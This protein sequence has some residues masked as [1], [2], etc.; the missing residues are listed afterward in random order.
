MK[1]THSI[2]SIAASL[3]LILS[4]NLDAMD[5]MMLPLQESTSSEIIPLLQRGRTR[6]RPVPPTKKRK[7]KK[8]P[9]TVLSD[10]PTATSGL[11]QTFSAVAASCCSNSQSSKE[12]QHPPELSLVQITNPQPLTASENDATTFRPPPPREKHP[13][14]RKE[15]PSFHPDAV[16]TNEYGGDELEWDDDTSSVT[17]LHSSDSDHGDTDDETSEGEGGDTATASNAIVTSATDEDNLASVGEDEVADGSDSDSDIDEETEVAVKYYL[18]AWT[19]VDTSGQ[20]ALNLAKKMS[21][22]SEYTNRLKKNFKDQSTAR[23]VM[24][25]GIHLYLTNNET[26]LATYK[27]TKKT[28]LQSLEKTEAQNKEPELLTSFLKLLTRRQRRLEAS[29]LIVKSEVIQPDAEILLNYYNACDTQQ[30]EIKNFVQSA[31]DLGLHHLKRLESM[32]NRTYKIISRPAARIVHSSQKMDSV[33]F[34]AQL[35]DKNKSMET[36]I[37]D[38]ETE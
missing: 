7:G 37:T 31:I 36:P 23:K 19:M 22:D 12:V 38:T 1:E 16:N 3:L 26:D 25:D 17:A 20:T 33:E 14:L 30:K 4:I 35:M 5:N 18:A 10:Q 28:T 2:L 15:A 13:A 21:D 24:T 29:R 6:T 27:K 32:R 8:T 11:K 34:F 9:K